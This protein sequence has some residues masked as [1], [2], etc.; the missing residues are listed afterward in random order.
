MNVRNV[1]F[2]FILSALALTV[3]L[4]CW[5]SEDDKL[6]ISTSMDIE[7]S[8]V[9]IN[10]TNVSGV[11]ST[12]MEF[13]KFT[14]EDKNNRRWGVKADRAIQTLVDNVEKMTLENVHAYSTSEKG[15]SFEFSAEKGF[16][17]GVDKEIKLN[18]TVKMSGNGYL[19]ETNQIEGNIQTQNF[20]TKSKIKISGIKGTIKAGQFS[21]L[22][23]SGQIT[24][25]RG[26]KMRIFPKRHQLNKVKE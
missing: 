13:P 4:F 12:V 16:F 8:K 23:K 22:G 7:K 26:V 6:S 5:P 15:Q 14:G 2:S 18:G 1:K 25:S 21:M 10:A 17:A 9:T 19:L 3:L 11:A 20:N 24:L